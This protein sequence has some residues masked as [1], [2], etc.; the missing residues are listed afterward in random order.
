MSPHEHLPPAVSEQYYRLDN[1]SGFPSRIYL[2]K[3]V[4]PCGP[5]SCLKVWIHF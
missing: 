2:V 3:E 1:G 5:M 4:F